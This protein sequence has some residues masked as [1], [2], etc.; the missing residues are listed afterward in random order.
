MLTYHDGKHYNSLRKLEE[1]KEGEDDNNNNN[2]SSDDEDDE[3]SEDPH[4]NDVNNLIQSV[5]T[6]NI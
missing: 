3:S 6:L 4:L 5:K 2:S 1:R